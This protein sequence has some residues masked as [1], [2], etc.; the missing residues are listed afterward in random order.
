MRIPRLLLPIAAAALLAAHPAAAQPGPA[1]PR[2]E[3]TRA[4]LE[5]LLARS[6][7]AARSPALGDEARQRAGNEA[8]IIRARLRDGDLHP[9]DQVALEVEGEQALTATFTVSTGR[10]LVL[11]G[12]E[13]LPLDGV[14]R[15][16]L[17]DR[18]RAHVGRYIRQPVVRARA[19]LRVAV[20]GQVGT[21]GFYSVPA[22]SMVSDVIMAAGGPLPTGRISAARIERGGERIWAGRSLQDAVQ[23]GLTL[24]Q[25]SLRSGDAIFI[26][27]QQPSRT[28]TLL[29]V[30]TAVPAA[31]L[32]VIGMARLF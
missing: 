20:L 10:E 25:M 12:M 27:E 30:A 26:P 29:R 31:V 28:S 1:E 2:R 24:D 32:A 17:E 13:P 14:L 7:E 23:Y 4:E 18:L 3:P 8:E 21:P 6:A 15:T 19:M 22:E 16:E 9:G 5:S 11:P